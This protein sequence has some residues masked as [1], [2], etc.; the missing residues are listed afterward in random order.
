MVSLSRGMVSS[1]PDMVG[2]VLERLVS[3][4]EEVLS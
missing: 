3:C 4:S 1:L 2:A